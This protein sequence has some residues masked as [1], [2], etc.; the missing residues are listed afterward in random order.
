MSDM[1]NDERDHLVRLGLLDNPNKAECAYGM[2]PT[3]RDPRLYIYLRAIDEVA[4]HNMYLEQTVTDQ[5]DELRRLH[6]R[7]DQLVT[8]LDWMLANAGH[9]LFG[10]VF[11]FIRGIEAGVTTQ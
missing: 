8:G 11:N 2:T 10:E 3:R 1:P 5:G 6:Q 7:V 4:E 9:P